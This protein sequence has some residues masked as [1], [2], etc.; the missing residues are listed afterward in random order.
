MRRV[1]RRIYLPRIRVVRRSDFNAFR[2][3][4]SAFGVACFW[5]QRFPIRFLQQ[6][7]QADQRQPKQ[8]QQVLEVLIRLSIGSP[9]LHIR[10]AC[11]RSRLVGGGA[12][13]F[14]LRRRRWRA[15]ENQQVSVRLDR[16]YVQRET[17]RGAFIHKRTW[18][19]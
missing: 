4:Y 16:E 6:Q 14:T 1:S 11:L 13:R 10:V 8:Y 5:C 2:V 9:P 12:T 17:Y 7:E 3:W 19:R 15:P 18:R